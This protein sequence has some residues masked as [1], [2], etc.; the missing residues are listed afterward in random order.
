MQ[1][2]AVSRQLSALSQSEQA[3]VTWF[4]LTES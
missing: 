2:S 1:H 4:G 3:M